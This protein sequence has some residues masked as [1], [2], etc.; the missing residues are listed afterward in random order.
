MNYKMQFTF[1]ALGLLLP[2]T[3][4]ANDS[5]SVM[6][7][8]V[9][10]AAKTETQRRD[11]V[12][13]IITIDSLDI[14]ESTAVSFGELLANETGIDWRTYGDYGGA[15]STLQMRG[16]ASDETMVL[17]NGVPLNSPSLGSADVSNIPLNNIERIEIVKGSGSLLYGSGAMA[18]VINII[19]KNPEQEAPTMKLA[20]SYG[21]ND[22]YTLSLQHS[23]FI[24]QDFGYFLSAN[25]KAGDGARDNSQLNHN[26]ASLKLLL[27]KGKNF[28]ASLYGQYLDRDFGI[29][30]FD[31]P[32]G[33]AAPN[34][35]YPFYNNEVTSLL[36][37]GGDNNGQLIFEIDSNPLEWLEV[38]I[39]A[40]L[41]DMKAYTYQRYNYN[42]QGIKSWINNEVWGV[43]ANIDLK[44][45]EGLNVLMGSSYKHHDWRT[46]SV[47]LDNSGNETTESSNKAKINTK[48]TY[49]EARYNF[50]KKVSFLAGIRHESHSTFGNINLPHYGVVLSPNETTNIKINNGKHFMAPTPNDL[51]WPETAW[52]R[53]NPDLSP[54]T[55]WHS[56]ITIEKAMLDNSLFLNLSYFD[57]NTKGKITWAPNPA[58]NNKWTPTNMNSSEG[59]GYEAGITYDPSEKLTIGI[60]YTYTDAHDTLA[61]GTRKA[62]NQAAHRAKLHLIYRWDSGLQATTT[63]RYTGERHF[64]RSNG[65]LTPTDTIEDFISTDLKLEKQVKENWKVS[66]LAE[67]L[68]DVKYD[69][70]VSNFYASDYLATFT[71]VWGRYPGSGLS[72]SFKI[73]Y[74]Y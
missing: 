29:P 7:E 67:N 18:G 2:A 23:M 26:D 63:F 24:W 32:D 54:Q 40:D 71:P 13:S 48:G 51:F 15:S 37:H 8:V 57:W 72:L 45:L 31:P 10:T 38:N 30:G 1:A 62:Q 39:Q 66:L 49:L 68:F 36:D 35:N 11:V 58:F 6:D 22:T 14:E 9:V 74:E 70:Y 60:D 47:D 3:A 19:T 17:I 59:R 64:F 42:G 43:E 65:D 27:D 34:V 33:A 46:L 12:N 56:D 53:G 16:M 55:G 41:T 20:S 73:A 69:T 4:Q 28:K 50:L 52:A 21:T 44:P 61:T 5:V 25:H